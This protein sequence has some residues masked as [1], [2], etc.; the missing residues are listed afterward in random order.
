MKKAVWYLMVF[1]SAQLGLCAV[2]SDNNEGTWSDSYADTSGI[3]SNLNL[4]HD[5]F[6]GSF[7][8]NGTAT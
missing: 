1:F 4:L 5:A 8:L 3:Y 7:S 6:S 2:Q